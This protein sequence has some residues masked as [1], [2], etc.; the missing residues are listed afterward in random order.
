M[1]RSTRVF[2]AVGAWAALTGAGTLGASPVT[3]TEPSPRVAQDAVR[4][5][6][7]GTVDFALDPVQRGTVPDADAMRDQMDELW[8]SRWLG[9]SSRRSITVRDALT[10]EHLVDIRADQPLTPAS[11]TKL[12]SAAAITAVLPPEMTFATRVVV[13]EEPGQVVLVAG[14]DQLLATGSGSSTAVAGRA[15]L[16]D[17][18][19]ETASSLADRGVSGPID[20]VVD[21]TYA[22]GSSVAPAWTDFWV[23]NGFAG[24][25]SMLALEQDRALPYDPAP[26]DPGLSAARAFEQA[27][28]DAGIEVA[29]S[30]DIERVEA[31]NGPDPGTDSDQEPSTGAVLAEVE[32]APL[33]D[34]LALALTTSDNAMVEQL[35]RQ[36]AVASGEDTDQETVNAWVLATLDDFY[37]VD[38]DGAVLADT[39]GLSDGTR[40]PMRLVADVLVSGASGRYPALQS[41][42]TGLPIAGYSGTLADRFGQD[43]AS[44]GRGVVR[45]KTGSLPSVTSLAGT[46]TTAD[47]RLLVFALSVNDVG[48]GG[49][50]VE[51][52]AVIDELV[53]HLAGCGC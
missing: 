23:D 24:R 40:V 13:A 1:R 20:V 53:S 2:L 15:G 5:Q 32:S 42:L 4:P 12:L 39:S 18:A 37:A 14:G 11:T 10:D 45:A 51:A 3:V 43:V 7:P 17:L 31:P 6:L 22:D 16:A 33:R 50:E 46:V 26:R 35:A 44:E 9:S 49:A 29:T 25:I 19:A 8:D 47:G 36:A 38:T 41:V 27:L 34:V 30:G 28:A 48:S 21:T 52:R